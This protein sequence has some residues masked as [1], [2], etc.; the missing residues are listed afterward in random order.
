[1]NVRTFLLLVDYIPKIGNNCLPT[2]YL[3]T[4]PRYV[5]SFNQLFGPCVPSPRL[6][7]RV[8]THTYLHGH[9]THTE[10]THRHT[11]RQTHPGRYVHMHRYTYIHLT[12]LSIRFCRGCLIVAIHMRCS[13]QSAAAKRAAGPEEINRRDSIYVD[14]RERMRNEDGRKTLHVIIT[15]YISNYEV[16]SQG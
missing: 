1:M 3:P 9:H 2:A 7:P 8:R 14:N 15:S 10:E 5:R 11:R 16:G 12:Y 4:C 6:F 13:S